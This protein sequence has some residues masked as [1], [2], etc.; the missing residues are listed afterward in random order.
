MKNELF[1]ELVA[2]KNF[3]DKVGYAISGHP[4]ISVDK[5]DYEVWCSPLNENDYVEILKITY[6]GGAIAIR[7][8]SGDSEGAIFQEISKMLFGGYYDEV[9][10]YREMSQSQKYTQ[11][12]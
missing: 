7:N 2:K 12:I 4:R 1:L 3:T 9:I 8:V 10:W 5:I 6:S 11:I